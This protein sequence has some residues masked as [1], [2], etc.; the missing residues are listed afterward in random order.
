M[1]WF[2][3]SRTAPPPA[4]PARPE[5]EPEHALVAV[6]PASPELVRTERALQM[7]ATQSAQLHASI[8][9][10]E[11][12]VDSMSETLLGQIDRPSYDDMVEARLQTAKVAAELSRL[13]INIAARIDAVRADVVGAP[14]EIDLRH[15]TPADTG[16]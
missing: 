10:L 2:R 16:W 3:R 14:A 4:E 7:L 8:V 1:G 12:R 6:P 11:H 9:Q 13:E 15:A 5:P